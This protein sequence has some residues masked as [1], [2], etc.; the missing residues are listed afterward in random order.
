MEKGGEVH[1]FMHDDLHTL[2]G[3]VEMSRM[4]GKLIGMWRA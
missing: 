2:G 3:M 4:A 1:K